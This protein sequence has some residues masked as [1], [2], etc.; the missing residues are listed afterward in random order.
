M[1]LQR[2]SDLFLT[3][4]LT[5][6]LAMFLLWLLAFGWMSRESLFPRMEVTTLT[7]EQRQLLKD[8]SLAK[9]KEMSAKLQAVLDEAEK[10]GPPV[11]LPAE[12]P[13][14]AEQTITSPPA[15]ILSAGWVSVVDPW[16]HQVTKTRAAVL[17]DGWLA[18][19][20]RAMYA[21][22]KWIFY[23]DGGA[24]A[25]LARGIW[26]SGEA[27]GLW[28]LAT[29]TSS[30]EGLPLAPWST[31]SP[32]HWMSLDSGHELVDLH[33]APGRRQGDFVVC[34]PPEGIKE[35][36]VFLQ[37]A[38][39]V[40]WSFGPWLSDVYLWAGSSAAGLLPMT[41]VRAFYAA[42]FANGREEKF[43][44]ALAIPGDHAD[45]ERL[46][47]LVE[48]FAV[49]PKLTLADTPE[50][51]R[52]TAIVAWLRQLSTKL[53]R[54][55]HGAQLVEILTDPLLLEI[56]DLSL[57]MDLI[58]EFTASKGFE[59]AIQKIEGVGRQLVEKGGANVP[60]VNEVHL[61]LYQDWLQS[62][63]TAQAVNEVT[64][65]LNTAKAYYPNDP[66]IHLLAV[67]L[68]L[69]NNDWQ[70]AE[71]LL[72]L[73]EYPAQYQDRYE[74]LRHRISEMKGDV[75]TIVIRFPPGGTRIL[76]A[77]GLN[78]AIR[79][80]FIVDTG[81]SMLTIPSSTA[82]S[83]DLQVVQGGHHGGKR[84][85]ST[86][87]GLVEA[88]EV[89]IESV[90]VE[91]WVEHNVSALVMDIPDQPGIGLLGLNYLNR[92]KMDLNNNEGKL[93]LRPK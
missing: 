69:L 91:G 15:A 12:P 26:R 81:A 90:E 67:E 34:S 16:G 63:V 64:R 54:G 52:S 68:A 83:L 29:R 41:D 85:V 24:E 88:Y 80:E 87:G 33:L 13:V 59:A 19:P 45:L 32:L 17:G 4:K 50:Y 93:T 65:V 77:A 3:R 18:L 37:G 21:G 57:L 73:M 48:G 43:A 92:F 30:A 38:S 9:R 11:A 42:T 75:G 5:I 51:L 10:Q 35:N 22:Y 79:Q 86:A 2:H 36:G 60:M 49:Q 47:A 46:T 82:V 39:I 58:P 66:F 76:M 31:G 27:V 6:I 53:L 44:G 71:R 72:A 74:L 28:Q 78:Q 61:K 40:G 8:K 14:V 23:R 89:V 70:E 1:Q 84:S 7:A 56:G 25:E 20:M 55:G 62:L